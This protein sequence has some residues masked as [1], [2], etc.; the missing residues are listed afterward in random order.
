MNQLIVATIGGKKQITASR[1]TKIVGDATLEEII[2]N[3]T[4]FNMICLPGG[5]PGATNL[6][7]D[8]SLF[9]LLTS[10]LNKPG[11]ILAAI[12]AA[13]AVILGQHGLLKGL[14]CTCYPVDKFK[15]LIRDNGGI[16]LNELVVIASNDKSIIG[17]I[18][19]LCKDIVCIQ[20]LFMQS[21]R[22]DLELHCHFHSFW[23]IYCLDLR[24]PIAFLL[25]C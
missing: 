13:P 2:E 5:M 14:P 21:H 10:H 11:F 16:Y 9:S 12:C 15:Q 3:K 19:H 20:I 8:K 25:L 7:S 18:L 1:K 22:K 23:F 6:Y 4:Q 24:L 17:M